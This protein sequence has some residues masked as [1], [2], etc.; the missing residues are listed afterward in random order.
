MLAAVRA[1]AQAIVTLNLDDFPAERLD[2]YN[3]QA[4]HPDDFV[5]GTR[6]IAGWRREGHRRAGRGVEKPAS[7]HLGATR[8]LRDQRLVRSVAKLRELFSVG[9]L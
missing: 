1:G 5:I 8:S 2:P 7:I 3:I 4:K 6:P 9:D